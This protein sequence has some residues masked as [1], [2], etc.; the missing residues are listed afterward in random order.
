[1]KNSFFLLSAI[2]VTAA[3]S[4]SEPSYVTIGDS[5]PDFSVTMNDGSVVTSSELSS[6]NALVAFFHTDCGDCQNE[7]PVLQQFYDYHR[8]EVKFALISREE[9]EDEIFTYWKI[10]DLAMPYSAQRTRR[11]FSLFAKDTIPRCYCVRDGVVTNM[12]GDNPIATLGELE[13]S[14]DLK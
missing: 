8:N 7:L 11:I 1:M 14:F 12:F 2:L 9:S 3:C 4:K 10:N 6:G 5:L 13:R